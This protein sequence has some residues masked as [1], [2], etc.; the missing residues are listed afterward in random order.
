MVPTTGSTNTN[1]FVNI[2][3][4]EIPY[5]DEDPVENTPAAP[6]TPK[7]PTPRILVKVI[8]RNHVEISYSITRTMPMHKLKTHFA[9][10]LGIAYENIVFMFYEKF[11]NREDTAGTLQLT[12]NC[13]I[14]AFEIALEKPKVYRAV[15]NGVFV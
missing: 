6:Q 7:V 10:Q 11:V 4:D 3:M 2:E 15:E 14:M 5:I 8:K 1:S 13:K 12:N 9:S